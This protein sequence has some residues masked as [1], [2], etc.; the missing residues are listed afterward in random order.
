MQRTGKLLTA[1]ELNLK[2]DRKAESGRGI[3]KENKN[4]LK[5]Q[6][7]NKGKKRESIGRDL[8]F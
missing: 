2:K 6:K 4:E 3:K 8:S 1:V 5:S 7:G